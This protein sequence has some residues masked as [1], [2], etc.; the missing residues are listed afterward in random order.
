MKIR[1]KICMLVMSVL[2]IGISI[3]TVTS[4]HI[5]EQIITKMTE[6]SIKENLQIYKK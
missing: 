4:Y 3:S 6:D 1:N 2:V 5:T